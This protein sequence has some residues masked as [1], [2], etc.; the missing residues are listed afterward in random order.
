M[1]SVMEKPGCSIRRHYFVAGSGNLI[2]KK[3]W[4]CPTRERA[5]MFL[6]G[7]VS[8]LSLHNDQIGLSLGEN[9]FRVPRCILFPANNDGRKCVFN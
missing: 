3:S 4:Q 6:S 5:I 1:C 2:V 9:L 7:F 8:P